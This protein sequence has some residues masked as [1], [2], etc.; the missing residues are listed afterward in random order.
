[1]RKMISPTAMHN[2]IHLTMIKETVTKKYVLLF[3][4][5]REGGRERGGVT[6][7]IFQNCKK[8]SQESA[9]LPEKW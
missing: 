4:E 6:V 5:F 7:A 3:K 1:M 2:G 8:V 9:T